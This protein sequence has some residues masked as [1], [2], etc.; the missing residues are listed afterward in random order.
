MK[1]AF[2]DPINLLNADLTGLFFGENKI[3]IE[4]VPSGD[5]INK[6]CVIQFLK[7]G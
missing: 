7:F 1:I 4:G 2:E 3:S 5:R 6:P